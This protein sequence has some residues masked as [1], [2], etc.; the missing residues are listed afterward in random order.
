MADLLNGS[1]K[2]CGHSRY[3]L[4][5]GAQAIKDF[6][7]ENNI[8]FYQEYIFLDLPKRRFDFAIYDI[9]KP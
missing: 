8:A 4:S 2:N 6:L 5:K 3:T 7:M 1:S 9:Q